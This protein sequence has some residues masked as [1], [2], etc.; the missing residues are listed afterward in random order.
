MG[1][2]GVANQGAGRLRNGRRHRA[3]P[4]PMASGGGRA[5]KKK[6]P[7]GRLGLRRWQS[8]ALGRT[9]AFFDVTNVMS[10]GMAALKADFANDYRTYDERPLRALPAPSSA[11]ALSP[12]R[13]AAISALYKWVHEARKTLGK[14]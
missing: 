4:L 6:R 10:Y 8:D 5:G 9:K 14:G 11:L 2:R 3:R 1:R 12:V 7:M 13:C